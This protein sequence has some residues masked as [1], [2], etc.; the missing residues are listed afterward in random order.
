MSGPKQITRAKSLYNAGDKRPVT[1]TDLD[2]VTVKAGVPV[3]IWQRQM[4][5][6]QLGWFGH[7]SHV[8]EIAEAFIYAQVVATGN[9]AGTAGDP[10]EGELVARIRDSDDNHT[11]AEV[12]IDTLGE[13]AD[14]KSESRT[15][16]PVLEALDPYAKPGRLLDFAIVSTSASDGY[17]IDNT[18]GNSDV[19]LYYSLLSN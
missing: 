16:R 15:D 18:A 11:L 7:G 3:S 10:I 12:T 2:T 13:L 4:N 19:R 17:E 8:R 5:Q 14:A 6:D 9:G 1:E